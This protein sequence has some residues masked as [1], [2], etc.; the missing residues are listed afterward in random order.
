[1]PLQHRH[2][3]IVVH[4]PWRDTIILYTIARVTVT[5]CILYGRHCKAQIQ[6]SGVHVQ[7]F[8]HGNSHSCRNIAVWHLHESCIRRSIVLFQHP[9]RRLH[10]NILGMVLPENLSQS[11]PHHG[12]HRL[13]HITHLFVS[14]VVH[15]IVEALVARLDRK[16]IY[17]DFQPCGDCICYHRFLGYWLW[18]GQNRNK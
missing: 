6:A 9:A 14:S 16:R 1:M 5:T 10:D 4:I 12:L 15:T 3:H 2:R 7:W 11:M 13:Q 17:T 18:D 8:F